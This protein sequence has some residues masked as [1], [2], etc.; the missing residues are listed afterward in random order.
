MPSLPLLEVQLFDS[1]NTQKKTLEATSQQ[2][3]FKERDVF[4]TLKQKIKSLL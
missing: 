1:R 2:V 3:L 4:L